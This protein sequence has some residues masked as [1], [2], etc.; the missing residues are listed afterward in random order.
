V[1]RHSPSLRNG[2]SDHEAIWLG[3]DHSIGKEEYWG[4]W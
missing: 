4:C 2:S 3:V 1:G